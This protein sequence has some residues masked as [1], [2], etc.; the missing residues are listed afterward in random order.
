MATLR[1]TGSKLYL[2]KC[3]E[4]YQKQINVTYFW[5][6][7]QFYWYCMFVKFPSINSFQTFS[8]LLLIVGKSFISLKIS[9]SPKS[10]AYLKLLGIKLMKCD[11]DLK[12]LLSKQKQ[13][14]AP[15]WSLIL[16]G[17]QTVSNYVLC[18]LATESGCIDLA[19]INSCP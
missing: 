2:R 7:Y 5:I 10:L 19:Q 17:E 11:T 3:R 14:S 4:F 9:N 16:R 13:N 15:L 12:I 18:N 6:Q 1:C 8:Y